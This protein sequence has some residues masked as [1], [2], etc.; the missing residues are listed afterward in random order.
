MGHLYEAKGK[1]LFFAY[2]TFLYME[3]LEVTGHL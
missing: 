1:Y 3:G 2:G